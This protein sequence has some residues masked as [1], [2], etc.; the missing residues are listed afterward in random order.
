MKV[1]RNRSRHI[2]VHV[3]LSTGVLSEQ[4]YEGLKSPGYNPK[5]HSNSIAETLGFQQKKGLR[6]I[7][8]RVE[9]SPKIAISETLVHTLF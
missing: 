8:P 1:W 9:S 7:Q 2:V 5:P 3:R 4:V 6:L